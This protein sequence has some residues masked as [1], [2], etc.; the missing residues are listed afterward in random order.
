MADKNNWTV[1]FSYSQLSRGGNKVPFEWRRARSLHQPSLPGC[2]GSPLWSPQGHGQKGRQPYPLQIWVRLK[3]LIRAIAFNSVW[4]SHMKNRYENI[5][6][7]QAHPV[8]VKSGS[9]VRFRFSFKIFLSTCERTKG[10]LT[11]GSLAPCLV[12][13]RAVRWRPRLAGTRQYNKIPLLEPRD[14]RHSQLSWI[15]NK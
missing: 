13:A 14:Y 11:K 7:C 5:V 8:L 3:M 2:P 12:A 10:S 6:T 15:G 1:Q 4:G 9:N